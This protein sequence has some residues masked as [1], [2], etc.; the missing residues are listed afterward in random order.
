M[1]G[2]TLPILEIMNPEDGA[3]SKNTIINGSWI[4]ALVTALPPNPNG[5]GLLTITGIV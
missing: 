4:P 2:L 3:K 5:A 1:V